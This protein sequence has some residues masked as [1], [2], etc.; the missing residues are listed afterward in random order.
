LLKRNATWSSIHTVFTFLQVIQAPLPVTHSNT[1]AAYWS[2]T[3]NPLRSL[4]DWKK[5]YLNVNTI[6]NLISL[7]TLHAS[8]AL[9]TTQKRNKH[10]VSPWPFCLYLFSEGHQCFKQE[11]LFSHLHRRKCAE[12]GWTFKTSTYGKPTTTTK[13]NKIKG[14]K[15]KTS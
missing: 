9:E 1:P 6:F 15:W 5:K 13:Y 3:R 14:Y 2:E 10:I 7:H 4:K 8:P 12:L 11:R